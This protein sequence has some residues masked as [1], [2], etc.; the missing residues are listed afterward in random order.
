MNPRGS[1]LLFGPDAS[2]WFLRRNGLKL[3]IR[4]HEGPEAR[5]GRCALKHRLAR[6]GTITHGYFV[7]LRAGKTWRGCRMATVLTTTRLKVCAAPTVCHW[8]MQWWVQAM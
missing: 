3:I 8:C 5:V 6:D 2:E 1:G 4:S 7:R